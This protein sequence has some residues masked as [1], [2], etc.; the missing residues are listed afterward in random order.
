[1]PV[2]FD[3]TLIVAMTETWWIVVDVRQSDDDVRIANQALAVVIDSLQMRIK[4]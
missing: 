3:M 1:M 4:Q 2:L